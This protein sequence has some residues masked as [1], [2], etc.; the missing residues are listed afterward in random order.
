MIC[1]DEI[2]NLPLN[3]SDNKTETEPNVFMTKIQNVCEKNRSNDTTTKISG[4][5][6]IVNKVNG[7]Y[8]VGRAKNIIGSRWGK[9]KRCLRHNI[10]WN[11]H[12]QSAWNKYGESNFEFIVTEKTPLNELVKTEQKYLDIA[13][14]E[15]DKLQFIVYCR[16]YRNDR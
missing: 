13:E 11:D 10:H 16:I 3:K 14:M 6:K 7:K 12:L 4:I 2:T 9:H 5:Y 1:Q 8:Y 15:K